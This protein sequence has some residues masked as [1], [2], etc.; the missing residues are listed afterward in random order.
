MQFLSGS[1]SRWEFLAAALLSVVLVQPGRAAPHFARS[2]FV[3]SDVDPFAVLDPQ[4]WVN[5]DNMTWE[6]V[7]SSHILTLQSLK[8]HTLVF[9]TAK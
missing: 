8:S 4:N 7:C 1:Q 3:F 2:E 5:P 9:G 6:D